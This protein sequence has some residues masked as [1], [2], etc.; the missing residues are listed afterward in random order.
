MEIQDYGYGIISIKN[1]G[2]PCQSIIKKFDQ[3]SRRQPEDV[4][5]NTVNYREGESLYISGLSDWAFEDRQIFETLKGA[6]PLYQ[7]KTNALVPAIGD[8]GYRVHRYDPGQICKLHTDGGPFQLNVFLACV[9]YLNDNSGDLVFPNHNVSY[10][11]VA[12]SMVLFPTGFSYPHVSIPT[13]DPRYIAVTWMKY[14]EYK[15]V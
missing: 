9:F 5:E 4:R 10:R 11:P 12:D 2:L 15:M 14:S 7:D 3:D 13:T 8:T 1:L 6:L